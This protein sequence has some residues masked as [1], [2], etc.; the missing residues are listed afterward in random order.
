MTELLHLKDSYIREFASEVI[1]HY[2]NGVVLKE[3][4]FYPRGGGQPGDMGKLIADGAEF[5]VQ[6]VYKEGKYVIHPLVA[7]LIEKG[8]KVKGIIDWE[9]RHRFMRTHS[10]LHILCGV[11]FRDYGSLVTGCQMYPDKARMD[12]AFEQCDQEKLTDIERK[13]NDVVKEG[14]PVHIKIIPREEAFRIP[15]LIRTKIN[16]LPPFIKEVRTVE[17][18]NLDLQA[19]GGTHVKNTSEI[20]EVKITKFINKGKENKRIEIQLVE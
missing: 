7:G 2:K 17:I 14:R 1:D 5:S 20:G 8:T 4:A 10:A 16:L 19:D 18:E 11:I 3:T 6:E 13:L 9:R 15:D 12:F